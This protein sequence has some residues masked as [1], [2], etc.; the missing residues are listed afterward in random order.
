MRWCR[1]NDLDF[2]K[3]LTYEDLGKS[4]YFG[5]NAASG[6]L[7]LFLDA[8]NNDEIPKGSILL[9]ESL[10]SRLSRILRNVRCAIRSADAVGSTGAN[11]GLPTGL[12]AHVSQTK[13][14]K[15]RVRSQP[16]R[17]KLRRMRI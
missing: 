5:A 16:N 12:L 10:D 8:L 11:S 1:E 7:S 4:A 14:A 3:L 17:C 13:A 6:Q 2:E 15:S 9:V